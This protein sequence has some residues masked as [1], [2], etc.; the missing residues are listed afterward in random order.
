[1]NELVKHINIFEHRDI[2]NFIGMKGNSVI[3]KLYLICRQGVSENILKE[4]NII[5]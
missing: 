2:S 1:M 3:L 5:L 4:S